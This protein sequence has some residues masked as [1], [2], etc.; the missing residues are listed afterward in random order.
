MPSAWGQ[1]GQQVAGQA[2]QGAIGIGVQRIGAKYDRKQQLKTQEA[3]MGLQMKGMKEMSEFEQQ[4]QMEMWE[5]TGYGAQMDQLKRAGLNPG[6]IYGQGGAGGQTVGHGGGTPSGG[7]APYIDTTGMGMQMGMQMRMQ[8]AQIRLM[9][10]QARKTD[11]EADITGGVG[12]DKIVNEIEAIKAG[13]KNTEA[14]EGYTR[15]QTEL[16]K[17]QGDIT[18]KTFD[19]QVKAIQATSQKITQELAMLKRQNKIGDDTIETTIDAIRQEYTGILL[20]N[21]LKQAGIT[22]TQKQMDEIEARIN[23][24]SED[25]QQGWEMISIADMRNVIEKALGEANIEVGTA[26]AENSL[27]GVIVQAVKAGWEGIK[28]MRNPFGKQKFSGFKFGKKK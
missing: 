18:S 3:M 7:T 10:S 9:E 2:A 23:K 25:I 16:G 26:Q 22:L 15:I 28:G 12:K 1:I 14:Q 27:V 21:G 24:M 19:E 13:I 6:L 4:Q 17:L 8:E 11:V 20:D 5:N